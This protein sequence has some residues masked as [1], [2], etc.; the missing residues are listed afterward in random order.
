MK[1]HLNHRS[2]ATD[3]KVL[4][5]SLDP[6]IELT[7]GKDLPEPA[8]YHILVDGVPKRE[9]VEASPNLKSLVIPWAGLP[10]P[11]RE[12]MLE[13]PQ[14]AVHNLHHNA[15]PTAETALALLFSAAKFVIP[16]DK[17]MRAHNWAP[18]Y[19]KTRSMLLW[20]KT[21]L[22][23]GYGAIGRHVGQVLSA[24]QMRVLGVRRNPEAR[25]D[26]IAEIYG[27]E[28]ISQ[29]LPQA[30]V[31]V[32]ALPLTPETEGFIGEPELA[33]MPR[34]AL[35]VN[36]GRGP[37]VDAEAL[38]NALREGHLRGA[39]LDV[40][41]NYPPDSNPR[42]PTPPADFPFHELDN[43]VMSPHRGGGSEDTAKLRMLHLAELL[44]TAARGESLPNR[45]DLQ[46]GS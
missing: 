34:G 6:R 16:Y 42:S 18:R 26:G 35:L 11:T 38:F 41:Y 45:V 19:E 25:S 28:A 5:D 30:D 32:I 4:K 23:L 8:E 13:Y 39:G 36:V 2:T 3:L 7:I 9:F 44:N 40:W 22:I 15:A 24:M 43:V 31:L 37:I 1:V 27:L 33:L 46:A 21:A 17:E 14:I 10:T 20:G 29:L 12:L